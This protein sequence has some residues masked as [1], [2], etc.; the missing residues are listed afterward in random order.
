M[1]PSRQSS[2][3]SSIAYITQRVIDAFLRENIGEL[4]SKGEII[5]G[6]PLTPIW[7]APLPQHWLKATHLGNFSLYLPLQR[8]E[9]IQSWRIAHAQWLIKQDN[10]WQ[11]GNHYSLWLNQLA[12]HL[13]QE[14][15]TYYADFEQECDCAVAH[16]DLAIQLFTEQQQQLKNINQPDLNGWQQMQLIE[17]LAAHCDHPLYPT[18]RAKSGLPNEAIIHY[19]PETMPQFILNWVAIPQN[20]CTPSATIDEDFWP[21]F[22]QVGLSEDLG[23][24]FILVPIHPQTLKTYLP[25]TLKSWLHKDS[26][27]F[28][29]K[30]FLTVR[31]TLSVR[32]VCLVD[33]P[34]IHI[35]LPLPM[36]TLGSKNIRTIKPSTIN[37]GY[38]FQQL[39]EHLVKTDQQFNQRYIHCHE[40]HGGCVDQRADLAWLIRHYPA[41][42]SSTSPVCVAAFLAETSQGE[43][44]IEQLA[45]RYYHND[46]NALLNDYFTLILSVHMRLL[47][48]YGIALESN[49]QN[50]LVLFRANAPLQLLFRDNDAGRID[51]Q[52]L[53]QALPNSDQPTNQFIEQFIDQRIL[54]ENESPLIQMFTTINLQ[55]NI[56]CIIDGLAS[57][58]LISSQQTYV[59]VKQIIHQELAKIQQCHTANNANNTT[60]ITTE[61]YIEAFK[62]AILDAPFHY[63]K[64]LLSAASLMSKQQSQATDINKYYGLS[65]PN[66]LWSTQQ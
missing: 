55:L 36:R 53:R 44:V 45:K 7:D 60:D 66:P 21:T 47:L 49:Q 6:Q 19:C 32:T 30:P 42:V 10:K 18:A 13:T 38:V 22:S 51:P 34:S 28:A 64:Y 2:I 24:D 56:G 9:F 1:Q 58:G 15:R 26:V 63:A 57:R 59:V 20:L 65:A 61:R 46:L 43:T 17:Q 31:P 40:Q 37:D 12:T 52:K 25:E 62:S 23:S 11:I 29:P 14:Q 5:N 50:T 41:D 4:I 35:K 3:S 8:S 33:R 54:V 16:K 48:I 27:H 39:L